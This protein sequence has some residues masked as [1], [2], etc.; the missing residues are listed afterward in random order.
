M[1]ADTA[2][3]EMP[4]AEEIARALCIAQ[5]NNPDFDYDPNG[6]SDAPGT[7]LCWKLYLGQARAILDLFAPIL[8]E[9][10]R[11]E[12]TIAARDRRIARLVWAM[13]YAR[14]KGIVFPAD[15]EPKVVL[16]DAAAIRAQGE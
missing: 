2:P 3:A 9:K 4:G 8:A 12:R 11:A 7:N 1:S 10:E 5:G 14:S 16:S 6:I 15:T 13:D